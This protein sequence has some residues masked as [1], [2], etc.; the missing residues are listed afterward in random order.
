MLRAKTSSDR[1]LFIETSFPRTQTFDF[2]RSLDAYVSLHR[3]EGFGLTCAEAMASG[4]PVI[5]SNYS[6]NLGFM[7]VRVIHY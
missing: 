3:A 5:A 1:I 4:L 2:M 7:E 6:G